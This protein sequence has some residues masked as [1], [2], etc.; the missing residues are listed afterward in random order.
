MTADVVALGLTAVVSILVPILVLGI[1]VKKNPMER[2]RILTAFIVGVVIYLIVRMGIVEQGLQFLF[3]HTSLQDFMSAHYIPYLLIVAVVSAVLVMTAFLLVV[4]LVFKSQLSFP[5]TT[6]LAFGYSTAEAVAL[7]GYRSICTI[8]E[9]Y[10]NDEVEISSSTAE[11]FLNSYER[12]L[13][14][15]IHVAIIVAL[16]YFVEEKMVIRGF[17]I[18]IFAFTMIN[19]LPGFFIA[20]TTT[21]YFEVFERSV[22]LTFVYLVLTVA[23][24]CGVCILNALKYSLKD[25]RVDSKQAVKKFEKK[26][27][28]KQAKKQ[29]KN[30][31]TD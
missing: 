2:L 20:F 6:M 7:A 3:N 31:K 1:V 5:K 18:G 13:L 9:Y 15:V 22:A 14:M 12:I 16:V 23:A 27:T 25:E 4:K 17:F 19:F 10:S 28:E 11:L 30:K 26:Q 29:A 21:N 8:I 24:I